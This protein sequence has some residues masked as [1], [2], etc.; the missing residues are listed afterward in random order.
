MLKYHV[1]R[2]LNYDQ[3]ELT[4]SWTDFLQL[5]DVPL[6]G[7]GK[8]KRSFQRVESSPLKSLLT[9]AC[10]ESLRSGSC[11]C[12]DINAGNFPRSL[13]PGSDVSPRL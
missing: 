7:L 4:A 1:T 10:E 2:E 12:S 9:C 8:H 13:G 11:H 3:F 5:K 6:T